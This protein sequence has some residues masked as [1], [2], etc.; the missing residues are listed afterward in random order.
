MTSG[1]MPKIAVKVLEKIGLSRVSRLERTAS[2]RDMPSA[3]AWRVRATSR[4]VLFT[5]SPSTMMK[6]IMVKRS[7]GW[8]TNRPSSLNRK[9]KRLNSSHVSENHIRSFFLMI[10]RP[11]RSTLFPYTTLFRSVHH[12]PQHDDEADHGQEVE[13]LEHEQAEQ[14]ERRHSA[15]GA[16]RQ[17]DGGD[18]G[19][20]HRLEQC[21]HDEEQQQHRE[22]EILA[23]VPQGIVEM[24]GRGAV[25]D[26]A[27]RR[28][29]LLDLRLD[30]L[31]DDGHGG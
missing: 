7:S 19:I 16:E 3:S 29:Q 8:N 17:R 30:V 26:R 24:V 4:M 18:G 21:R 14:P 20:L 25:G 1:S 31:V 6:P 12:Q 10:R 15:H 11:P 28:Q 22:A 23:H 2:T 27:V 5:T 13:R 9:S